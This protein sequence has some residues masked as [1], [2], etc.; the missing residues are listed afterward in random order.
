MVKL[1]YRKIEG[2]AAF[3]APLSNANIGSPSRFQ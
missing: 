3:G 2:R 1:I